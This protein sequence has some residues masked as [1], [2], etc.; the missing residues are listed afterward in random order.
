MSDIDKGTLQLLE[1][2]CP[3][4]ERY[5]IELPRKPVVHLPNNQV[6]AL[7]TTVR[8]F[9]YKST[10]KFQDEYVAMQNKK[11]TLTNHPV[12]KSSMLI[13]VGRVANAASKYK[14]KT[15]KSNLLTGSYILS[16]MLEPFLRFH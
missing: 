1:A 6:M 12:E 9:E 13:K 14:G 3:H 2:K 4:N 16:N 11:L 8:R 15:F 5:K 7:G 10:E